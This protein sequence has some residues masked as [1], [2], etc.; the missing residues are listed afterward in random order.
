[1]NF[2]LCSIAL[3][4]ALGSGCGGPLFFIEL[5]Q[6]E[7]CKNMPGQAFPGAPVPIRTSVEKD[8]PLDFAAVLSTLNSQSEGVDADLRLTAL[9]LSSPGATMD[10]VE[11]M[12]VRL[13]PANADVA[14]KDLFSYSRSG[15]AQTIELTTKEKVNLIDYFTGSSLPALTISLTGQIPT[16]DWSIVP[17]ACLYLKT[18]VDTLKTIQGAGS[19]AGG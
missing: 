13:Q 2:R 10:W 5:E 6:K 12:N 7:L 14:P 9:T 3:L 16:S 15:S 19:A 1:M 17:R 11:S 18:K 4:L 8:F